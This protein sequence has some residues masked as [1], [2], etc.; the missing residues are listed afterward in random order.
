MKDCDEERLGCLT[1]GHRAAS[2]EVRTSCEWILVLCFLQCIC[3]ATDQLLL[4][5]RDHCVSEDI[6]QRKRLGIM[7]Y[8]SLFWVCRVKMRVCT[9]DGQVETHKYV[10]LNE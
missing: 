8:C 5:P 9:R 1:E 7:N 2:D 6:L 4:L 10:D 3:I